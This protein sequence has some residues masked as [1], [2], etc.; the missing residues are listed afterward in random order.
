MSEIH[1]TIQITAQVSER[2]RALIRAPRTTFF[3]DCELLAECRSC[4]ASIGEA[5]HKVSPHRSD[6]G[7][8]EHI[9]APRFN[10]YCA[11]V[12][13]LRLELFGEAVY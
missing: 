8:A 5:C 10:D 9:H 13:V 12:H 2:S 7:V 4:G 1:A 6:D 3:R 11:M